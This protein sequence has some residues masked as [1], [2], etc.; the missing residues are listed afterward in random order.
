MRTRTRWT[1]LWL[2]C[3]LL[4]AVGCSPGAYVGGGSAKSYFYDDVATIGFTGQA[5]DRDGDSIVD[6]VTGEFQFVN[7]TNGL[8]FHGKLVDGGIHYFE[9]RIFTFIAEG[10]Y[11]PIP[12]NAGPGGT[13]Q[14]SLFDAAG[15]DYEFDEFV[16]YLTGGVY[17]GY[18]DIFQI[19]NGS[20]RQ[21]DR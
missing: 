16:L 10:T 12:Q 11:S 8:A 19:E 9:D 15:S 5:R 18:Q 1:A 20:L 4:S 17:D 7:H 21:Q 3:L 13:F 14:V 6:D 2:G